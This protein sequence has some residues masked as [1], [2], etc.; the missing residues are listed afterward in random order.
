[1]KMFEIISNNTWNK[2]GIPTN[3]KYY[4]KCKNIE[5]V[6]E[7]YKNRNIKSIKEI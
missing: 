6:K 1:M 2:R 4:M 5:E 7:Y 3:Y